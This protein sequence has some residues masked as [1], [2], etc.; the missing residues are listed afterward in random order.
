MFQDFG[1]LWKK[2]MFGFM[3]NIWGVTKIVVWNRLLFCQMRR[4]ED[5]SLKQTIVLPNG[6]NLV[7]EFKNFNRDEMG[8]EELLGSDNNDKEKE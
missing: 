5:S 2:I 8:N 7:Q 1:G 3:R 6:S 4:Y